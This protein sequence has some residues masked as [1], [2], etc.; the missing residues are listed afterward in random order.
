[1]KENQVEWIGKSDMKKRAIVI[2]VGSGFQKTVYCI[3]KMIFPS[4]LNAKRWSGHILSMMILGLLDQ[5][6]NL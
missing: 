6:L 1:M 5:N 2:S 3:T 4:V